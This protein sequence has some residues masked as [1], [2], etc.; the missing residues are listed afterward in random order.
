MIGFRCEDSHM[1]T[2]DTKTGN[3]G[4]RCSD[5]KTLEIRIG[6]FALSVSV[7]L[8]NDSLWR[9]SV[10]TV[11]RLCR[12]SR[13]PYSAHLPLPLARHENPLAAD[14]LCA[15]PHSCVIAVAILGTY[16]LVIQMLPSLFPPSAGA[17]HPIRIRHR[18]LTP[19]R[20][21]RIE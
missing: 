8:I 14:K 16:L 19:G 13:R 21:S 17:A 12:G 2:L 11:S 3:L 18:I 4:R 5:T 6:Y 9:I 15:F 1:T 20:K 10:S 7:Y